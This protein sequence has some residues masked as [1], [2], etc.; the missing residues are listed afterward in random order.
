MRKAALR[1]HGAEWGEVVKQAI[2]AKLRNEDNVTI[3][4][5]HAELSSAH[6]NFVL[7]QTTLYRL[8]KGLGF[9]FTKNTGLK[10]IFER[11]DLVAKR[12]AFLSEMAA[13]RH[14][15]EYLIYMDETWVFSGMAN[16]KGWNDKTIPQFAP[17]SLFQRYSYGRT[18]C[19]NKGKRAIVIAAMAEDGIVDKS[20]RVVVSGTRNLESDYHADMNH[21]LFEKWLVD[22]LPHMVRRAGRR[23]VTLVMDNAP[24][25]CRQLEKLPRSSSTKGQIKDFLTSKG[26][27]LPDD[28]TKEDL[29]NELR[30]YID[31]RGGVTAL[32]SYATEQICNDHGVNL[33]R[34]PPFHCMFNPIELCWSQ[35]KAFLNKMGRTTDKIEVVRER[36]STW[37]ASVTRT[38]ASAWFRDAQA[39]ETEARQKELLDMEEDGSS[40]GGESDLEETLS[41]FS[42]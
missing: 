3:A 32:R 41:E 6:E 19:K 35:L 28:A 40:T 14:R 13:A 23:T 15:N 34:L 22:S 1:R 29:V 5:L 30:C 7:S 20:V 27:E 26:I 33:I 21:T 18:V 37:L 25:H 38:E 8:V 36:T 39:K 9:S 10:F 12:H 31:F 24:Y 42:L 4:D 11:A 16:K 17:R 2:H